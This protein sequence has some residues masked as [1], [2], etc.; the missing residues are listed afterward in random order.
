MRLPL[1]LVVF[2]A[3]VPAPA[4][5]QPASVPQRQIPAAVLHE[6]RTLESRFDAALGADCDVSR[7]FPK[8]CTYVEHAVA[9]RPRNSSL[10]GLGQ[11][12]APAPTMAQE[13]LTRASC[14]FAHE[15]N[16]EPGDVRALARRLQDKLSHGWL[17]VEVTHQ[18]LA[19]L[20]TYVGGPHTDDPDTDTDLPDEPAP[21]PPPPPLTPGRALEELWSTLLPHAWW[22]VLLGLGGLTAIGLLWAWRRLGQDSL[23]DRLLLAEAARGGPGAPPEPVAPEP[24]VQADPGEDL[25]VAEQHAAWREKLATRPVDPVVTALVRDLLR[26]GNLALLARATVRFPDLLPSAFPEGVAGGELAAAKLSL[27]EHL[28]TLPP[29]GPSEDAAFYQ[30]WN[31]H[32]LSAAVAAQADAAIARSLRDDFGTSGLASLILAAGPRTGALLYALAPAGR[33]DELVRLLEPSVL[34]DMGH[35]LLRS[36]RVSPSEDHHLRAVLA[37]A[38][39]ERTLPADPGAEVSDLGEPFDAAGPLSM[40]LEALRPDR[41]AEL[42]AAALARTHGALPD[43]TRQILVSDLLFALD[44]EARADLMLAV[45]AEPLAAWFGLL[46]REVAEALLE[47]APN[48]LRASVRGAAGFGT[49]E[50]Q[51]QLAARARSVLARGL[52]VALAR[53]G[54]TF[55]DVATA[56]RSA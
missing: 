41:R 4:W 30:D 21:P 17:T 23:E 46:D 16:V 13:Y 54:R 43:W 29:E 24:A 15:D 51:V 52:H 34:A 2:A 48:A 6:V 27:A 33:Q 3:L 50:A 5:A 1:F 32:A 7:C 53:S 35:M 37:A 28:R 8:G 10:P 11:E 55:A 39:A 9:D 49:R 56:R 38:R 42:V 25:Y 47:G 18:R 36:D 26:T 45:D 14:A 20:P 31:R 40:L 22:M 12:A 44:P 19:P